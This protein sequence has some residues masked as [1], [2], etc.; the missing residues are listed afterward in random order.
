MKR[1]KNPKEEMPIF[2]AIRKPNAPPSRKF[3]DAK[4]DEIARPSLRKAK[5]K[6]AKSDI[7]GANDDG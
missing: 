7:K 1:R 5:H 3:G 4:P 2:N 6:P